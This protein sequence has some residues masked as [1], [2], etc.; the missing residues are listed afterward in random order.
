MFDIDM[1][2]E[3]FRQEIL[4]TAVFALILRVHRD[5]VTLVGVLS[6]FRLIPVTD[7]IYCVRVDWA[8]S[9][10]PVKVVVTSH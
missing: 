6:L 3:V 1:A 5:W 2:L 10:A 8:A 9:P 7:G 4:D